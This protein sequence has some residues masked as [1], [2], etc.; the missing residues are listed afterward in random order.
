MNRFA[1][2]ALVPVAALLMSATPQARVIPLANGEGEALVVPANS[3][4]RFS[5]FGK[6]DVARFRG[7]FVLTG[8]FVY[9]CEI[10]CEPPLQSD[11]VFVRI[12]P[13]AASAAI[14]PRWMIRNGDMRIYLVGGDRLAN[15]IVTRSEKAALLAGKVGDVR[16]QVAIVVDDY[17]AGIECDSASYTARYVSLARPA[18]L[19]S[20]KMEGDFGCG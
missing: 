9:G 15:A 10:E 2:I 14:L 16:R 8:T 6:Y 12:V 3:P 13:D 5:G 18:Q 7:R 4:V 17:R 11:E 19:A 1:R 20:A